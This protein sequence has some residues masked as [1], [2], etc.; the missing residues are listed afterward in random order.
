M[1]HPILVENENK[2]LTLRL[3]LLICFAMFAAWQMGMVYFSGQ[4]MSVDGRTP[5]P[6]RVGDVTV[7]IVTGYILSIAVMIFMPRIIVWAERITA[8]AALLSALALFLPLSPEMSAAALYV[9][10]FCCCF[11]IGFETAIIIGLFSEKTAMIH[12]T[13]AYGVANGLVA[14]LQND[15]IKVD[16]TVFKA[17][18]VLALVL[19]LIFF[20]KLPTGVWTRTVKKSDGLAAPKRLF[21]GILFWTVMSCFVILFGN[22]VAETFTHGVFVFY[23]SSAVFCVIVYLLW[24]KLGVVPFKSF[25][26]VVA[27]GAMGFVL[28]IAALYV[29]ALSLA[30]CALLGIGSMGCWL[31]PLLGVLMLKEYPS[32]FIMP[33]II[34][35]AFIAVLIHTALLDLFRYNWVVLY[36]TYLVIAVS[37]VILYLVLAPYLMFTFLHRQADS[38]S[39]PAKKNEAQ[40]VQMPAEAGSGI[41]NWREMLQA[42]AYDRLSEGELDIAGYMMR[43]YQNEEISEESRYP[44]ET[45][46]TY[47]K[48]L[49]SKLQI[50][51]PRE[52]FARTEKIVKG[53]EDSL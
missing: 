22:A 17:F 40:P 42:N 35:A 52:L 45:V 25:S 31:N 29:P 26:A 28:A 3:P 19:M 53:K 20:W 10:Y 9:Q 41:L 34:G 12:L 38:V 13:I 51:K 2:R 23:L 47:R 16:F 21:A 4:T 48:R 36:V 7:L 11:M 32:R 46:K 43:G 33:G 14:I 30:A 37:L 1:N 18:T 15:F 44:L 24:Q 50:H 27:I 5:L 8:S 39:E 6:I 49:Y